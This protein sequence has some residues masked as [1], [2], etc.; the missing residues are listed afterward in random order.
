[1]SMRF[2][3]LNTTQQNKMSY[4]DFLTECKARG[5]KYLYRD[6]T[7]YA[8]GKQYLGCL[9]ALQEKGKKFEGSYSEMWGG[10][11]NTYRQNWSPSKRTFERAEKV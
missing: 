1:M 11:F 10:K 2:C 5:V 8:D 4:K 3:P 6:V 9:Y 7:V